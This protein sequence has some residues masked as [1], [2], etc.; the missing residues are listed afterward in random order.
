MD[1]KKF[2]LTENR[3]GWK[4]SENTLKREFPEIYNKIIYYIEEIKLKNKLCLNWD[5]IESMTAVQDY[6]KKYF[7]I[8]LALLK[9]F[10]YFCTDLVYINNITIG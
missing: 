1:Y 2:F 9:N 7:K 4:T 3:S 8:F 5:I 6:L 10:A